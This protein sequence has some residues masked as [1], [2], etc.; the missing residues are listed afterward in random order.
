MGGLVA[1]PLPPGLAV[2]R[3]AAGV[4][5]ALGVVVAHALAV[6]ERAL[7]NILGACW[8]VVSRLA[9]ALELVVAVLAVPACAMRGKASNR[10]RIAR[11]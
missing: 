6:G 1:L 9:E 10:V 2:A 5:E 3:V 11:A 4:V 8:P 7:V